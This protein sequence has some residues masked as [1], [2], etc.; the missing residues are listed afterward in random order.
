MNSQKKLL[1]HSFIEP[2]LSYLIPCWGT[3]TNYVLQKHQRFQNKAVKIIYQLDCLTPTVQAYKD[4]IILN[5]E[6]LTLLE[7]TKLI[8]KI[9]NKKKLLK[10][11]RKEYLRNDFAR[12]TKALKCPITSGITS[13]NRI[14]IH[15]LNATLINQMCHNLKLYLM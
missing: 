10:K 11:K 6:K 5:V 2:H 7:Q 1:Y 15:L 12:T 4:T 8:H 13:Y 14:P 3:A 9:N